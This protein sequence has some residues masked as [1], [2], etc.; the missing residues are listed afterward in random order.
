MDISDKFPIEIRRYLPNGF[1]DEVGVW[2]VLPL[3]DIDPDRCGVITLNKW[4]KE[5]EWYP[6]KFES[7]LW[8]G[9]DGVGNLLGWV[10]EKS[11]AILWNPADGCE[12][13]YSGEITALWAFI[14][15]NY[16]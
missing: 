15:N 13:W 2:F 16:E 12:Y 10:A 5:Q 6:A 14:S 1:K 8:F 11:S 4:L 7:I 3:N 9:D